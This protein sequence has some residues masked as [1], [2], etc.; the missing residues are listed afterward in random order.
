MAGI[1]IDVSGIRAGLLT[2]GS[3]DLSRL[4]GRPSTPIAAGIAAALR[5]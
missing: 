2:G 5:G 4:I 1:L 3:G